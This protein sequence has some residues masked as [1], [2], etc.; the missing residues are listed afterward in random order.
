MTLILATGNAWK[1]GKAGVH[2]VAGIAGADR[3]AGS[4]ASR[5]AGLIVGW[6]AAPGMPPLLRFAG[7]RGLPGLIRLAP[8]STP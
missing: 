1:A 3:L 6:Q 5:P 8:W 2:A 7:L 4:C